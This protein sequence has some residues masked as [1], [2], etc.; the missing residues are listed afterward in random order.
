MLPPDLFR[1]VLSSQHAQPPLSNLW[2]LDTPRAVQRVR[3]RDPIIGAFLSTR[4]KAAL[5]EHELC[6]Q[7]E[8]TS[9]LHG[10]PFG[11][12]DEWDTVELNTTGGSFRHRDRAPSED[13]KV[14]QTFRDAGAI[15]LGKTNLSDMGLSPDS[16]NFL[17]GPTRNPRDI[18]RAAGGSS[19]GAAAAVADGMVA[20]DWGTD[21]GGSIRTPAAFCGVYG[22]RLS[23][24]VWPID[25]MFPRVPA[26]LSWMCGQ[27][28]LA[29]TTQQLRAILAVAR[30][31]LMRGS[32]A[33]FSPRGAVLYQPEMPGE[34]PR[35]G[36]EI[37]PKLRAVFKRVV[38][39][40]RELPSTSEVWQL[41]RALW[42]SHVDDVLAVDDSVSPLRSVL[43]VASSLCARG[44]LGDFRIHPASAELLAGMML[45]R[46]TL[47]RDR[48]RV[49]AGVAR[50]RS[51]FEQVW[52]D[53]SVV[54]SPTCV[55]PAP[56][57]GVRTDLRILSCTVPGNLSD[58]TALS[59]PLGTF[60]G[61][62]PR[63][64]QLMGPPGSE[65]ALLDIADRLV[66]RAEDGRSASPG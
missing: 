35:F 25:G 26:A 52:A 38:S 21:I 17:I 8:P 40:R 20:F 2:P 4:L 1:P 14:F 43:A 39:L 27:G 34:W 12:K 42:A 10:V 30:P 32:P 61:G 54:V 36:D 48:R 44:K 28:P 18:G 53:G 11:L 64:L 6:V 41:Y 29:R 24:S 58:A 57:L 33:P 49:L 46:F 23:S 3:E 5:R 59:I 55:Y 16:C 19:G 65:E 60:A 31:R 47:F 45:G 63:A 62:M 9:P 66:E 7:R 22:L 37:A 15:L 50:V 56:R 13:S 51:A